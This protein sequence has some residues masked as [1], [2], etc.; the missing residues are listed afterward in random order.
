[1]SYS[2]AQCVN[3][4]I[5]HLHL[6]PGL[7]AQNQLLSGFALTAWCPLLPA[8]VWSSYIQPHCCQTLWSWLHY[9]MSSEWNSLF[10]H[11]I[12]W[13]LSRGH[14]HTCKGWYMTLLVPDGEAA[15]ISDWN[16]RE[17]HPSQ[18]RCLSALQPLE[19]KPEVSSQ[20]RSVQGV[21]EVRQECTLFPQFNWQSQEETVTT[22]TAF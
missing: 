12:Q 1:M 5:L 22:C 8:A 16:G 7:T 4:D 6:Q 17:N 9:Q 11:L 20:V 21:M 19:R 3:T 15:C 10:Y 18:G 14:P 2:E 13:Q